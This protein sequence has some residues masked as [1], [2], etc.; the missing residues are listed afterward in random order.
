MVREYVLYIS[1]LFT[2]VETCFMV[3]CK[4]YLE[5]CSMC[6]WKKCMLCYSCLWCS[7]NVNLAKLVIMLYKSSIFLLILY[8]LVLS[9]IG[10]E[11]LKSLPVLVDCV[12]SFQICRFFLP[13]LW[14]LLLSEYTF[15]VVTSSWC[16]YSV[17]ITKCSSLCLALMSAMADSNVATP[18]CYG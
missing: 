4:V 1:N 17:N 6:T 11:V 8:I 18:V 10:R 9:V 2:F 15:N 5:E 14:S 7:I 3:Q 13:I 16:L 12:F